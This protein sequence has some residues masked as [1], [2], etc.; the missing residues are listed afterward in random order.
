[1]PAPRAVLRDLA[2]NGLDPKLPHKTMSN[3]RIIART[4]G[5]EPASEQ[6]PEAAVK[7]P[8]MGTTHQVR[9]ALVELPAEPAEA[10]PAEPEAPLAEAKKKPAKKAKKDEPEEPPVS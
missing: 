2:A 9:S 6:A 5:G 1:M 8:K 7:G 10:K 3:G 4:V